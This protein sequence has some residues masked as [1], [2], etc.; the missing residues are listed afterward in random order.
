MIVKR[1][2]DLGATI[3]ANHPWYS[4][5][6]FYAQNIDAVPGG[7]TDAFDMIEL[8]AC[9]YDVE[10]IDT[11][12]DAT[13]FWNAYLT[14]GEHKGAK[15]GK[16]HYLVGASDTHDVRYPGIANDKG[17]GTIYHTG[18]ARTYAYVGESRGDLKA[19]GLSVANAQR[20]GKSYVSYGPILDPGAKVFGSKYSAANGAFEISVDI[21]SLN[22]VQDVLVLSNLGAEQYTYMG[23]DASGSEPEEFT[24]ENVL[25]KQSF[26]GENEVSF[27]YK[28]DMGGASDA[29]FA[30]MV[31]DG[32]DYQMF[33]ISNPYW[34]GK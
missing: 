20:D 10:T 9:S 19:V 29:W 11:I 7:Y 8:N 6:L 30:I 21:Q 13:A 34:V 2:H 26:N 14:G 12:N 4:Y 27:S 24:L 3:T 15:V 25:A 17:G 23:R 33:A 5:G 16:I 28:A 32:S 22:G 18:K 31:I 1:V